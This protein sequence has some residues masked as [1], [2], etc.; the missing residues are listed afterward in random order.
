M[1][2][3][4]KTAAY[5]V[6]KWILKLYNS[7]SLFKSPYALLNWTL[8]NSLTTQSNRDNLKHLQVVMAAI[9]KYIDV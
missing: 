7:T 9:L 2:Y 3:L 1:K 6:S 8:K 5:S 4:N